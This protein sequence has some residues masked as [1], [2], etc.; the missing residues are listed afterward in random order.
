MLIGFFL[1][2]NLQ[3]Y[4]LCMILDYK[5]LKF[6][7]LINDIAICLWSSENLAS[8]KDI[9]K[10]NPIIDL[11]KSKFT[12]KILGGVVLLGYSQVCW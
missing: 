6:K 2:Y 7:Y 8:I 3:S 10:C 9:W 5:N 12:K 1:L 4:F 11:L